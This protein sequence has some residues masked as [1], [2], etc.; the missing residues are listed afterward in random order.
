MYLYQMTSA[1]LDAAVERYYD[2]MLERYQRNMYAEDPWEAN[3]PGWEDVF[4]IVCDWYTDEALANLVKDYI[5]GDGD[6]MVAIYDA[7]LLKGYIPPECEARMKDPDNKWDIVNETFERYWD[8]IDLMIRIWEGYEPVCKGVC[9]KLLDAVDEGRADD[10]RE[11]YNEQHSAT[12]E[13]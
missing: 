11:R 7:G 8:D 1:Q 5:E 4:G 12:E 2:R 10:I 9:E 13:L 3:D 6:L